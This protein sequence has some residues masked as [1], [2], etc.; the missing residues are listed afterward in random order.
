LSTASVR[1]SADG[2]AY[3]CSMPGLYRFAEKEC[4]KDFTVTTKSVLESSHIPL[5]LWAQGFTLLC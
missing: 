5:S 1:P 4:R 3:A 2:R